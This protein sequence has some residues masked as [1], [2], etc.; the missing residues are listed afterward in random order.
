M[1]ILGGVLHLLLAC[2]HLFFQRLFQWH[3]ELETLSYINERIG[4]IL[5]GVLIFLLLEIALISFLFHHQIMY[6]ELGNVFSWFI[7]LTWIFRALLQPIYF[8]LRNRTSFGLLMYF[9]LTAICYII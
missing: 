8:G 5:N 2:F 4:K 1:V 7:A 6:S 3:T 9:L